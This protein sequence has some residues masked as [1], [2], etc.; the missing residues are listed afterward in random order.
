MSFEER[1]DKLVGWLGLPALMASLWLIVCALLLGAVVLNFFEPSWWLK[2][3]LLMT[4]VM[5]A[6]EFVF[7]GLDKRAAALDKSRIPER[8]LL[9]TAALGGWPGAVI[10][11]Q[12]FSHK[13][14]KT[15]YRAKLLVIIFAHIAIL[16]LIVV[17]SLDK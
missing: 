11:A 8:R 16:A 13:T 3:Y 15:S 12:V 1:Y 6:V 5:S 4:L 10:S 2:L 9:V 17:A 14:I 7:Y